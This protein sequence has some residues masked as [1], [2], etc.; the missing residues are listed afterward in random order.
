MCENLTETYTLVTLEIKTGKTARSSSVITP[1]S[2]VLYV[3]IVI[4][5]VNS[6][7]QEIS[8]VIMLAL[9]NFLIFSVSTGIILQ[10]T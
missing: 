7:G 6:I 4:C 3:R 9:L 5:V 8:Y 2:T 1:P 10:W